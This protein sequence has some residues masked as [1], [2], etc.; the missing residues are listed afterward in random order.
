MD[1][2]GADIGSGCDEAN[3]NILLVL[4]YHTF[5]LDSLCAGPVVNHLW[6]QIFIPAASGF[7]WSVTGPALQIY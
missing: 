2:D 3:V 6:I 7:V 1:M 5:V 4:G